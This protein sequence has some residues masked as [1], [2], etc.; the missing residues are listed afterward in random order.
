MRRMTVRRDAGP[1]LDTAGSLSARL[2]KR[3]FAA[4]EAQETQAVITDSWIG[5]DG[6]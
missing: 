4:K 5:V 6:F 1:E 2:P 3:S